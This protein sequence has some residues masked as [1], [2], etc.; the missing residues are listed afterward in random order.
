MNVACKFEAVSM[1]TFLRMLGTAA[2]SAIML[3]MIFVLS[4]IIWLYSFSFDSQTVV[5][6]EARARG[7]VEAIGHDITFTKDRVC[8]DDASHVY[9]IDV[10][11]LTDQGLESR[12]FRNRAV[13][14]N[15]VLCGQSAN[16]ATAYSV[17]IYTAFKKD[18]EQQD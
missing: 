6:H 10:N 8:V 18:R 9:R 14:G 5:W 1:K 4:I 17:T 3:M 16:G 12:T 7:T 11:Y 13:R 15:D 2:L